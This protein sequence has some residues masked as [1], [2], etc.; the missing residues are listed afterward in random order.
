VGLGLAQKHVTRRPNAMQR[1]EA[2]VERIVSNAKMRE[3][4]K[5]L[6]CESMRALFR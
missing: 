3:K 1:M 5:G 4:E 2:Q 6:H